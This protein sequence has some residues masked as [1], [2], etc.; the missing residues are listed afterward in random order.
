MTIPIQ[1]RPSIVFTDTGGKLDIE[2]SARSAGAKP[3]ED[4]V[5]TI[6]LPKQ[7]CSGPAWVVVLHPPLTHAASRLRAPRAGQFCI[8]HA[9]RWHAIVRLG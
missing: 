8:M 4:V 5:I 3:I 9:H 1:I 2:V 6:S 7:V